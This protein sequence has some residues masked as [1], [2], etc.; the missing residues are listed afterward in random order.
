MSV[1]LSIDFFK[2][3]QKKLLHIYNPAFCP[4]STLKTRQ[5]DTLQSTCLAIREVGSDDLI[6]GAIWK[7][8]KPGDLHHFF[9]L[10]HMVATG[11]P[12]LALRHGAL[13]GDELR[14]LDKYTQSSRRCKTNV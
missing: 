5:Y 4:N 6:F 1:S 14:R 8:L 7:L 12:R 3:K 9:P 10:L 13:V 11:E 2:K